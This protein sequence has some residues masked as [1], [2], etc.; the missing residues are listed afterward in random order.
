VPEARPTINVYLLTMSASSVLWT[1]SLTVGGP[2]RFWMWGAA[3]AADAAGPVAA[4]WR[5]NHLP[6]HMEHLPER[7]G[8]FVILVLGE[9]V[10][11]AATGVHDAK[12]AAAAV[13]VG[14]V[15]FVIAAA[16]WWTYFDTIAASS[17]ASLQRRDDE[18]PNG[19]AADERHDLFVYGHLPL[20]LGIVMAGVG[21][22]DLV[23]HPAAAL[24][25]PGSWTLAAGLA[26]FLVGS[27]LILGGSRRS[28]RAIWPW[29]TVAIPIV[30]AVASVPHGHALFLV[31]AQA[32]LI[33]LLAVRGKPR[34]RKDS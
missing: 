32:L 2:A 27:A 33:L 7:F 31:A 22:E 12:W 34:Y 18:T 13:A 17:A 26:L 8:L 3:V 9:T 4:T 23:L 6:L 30:L 29:P 14:I 5:D 11:G 10:G 21:I 1:V 19:H 25:S 24:P 28:W 16:M 15:G 20:A